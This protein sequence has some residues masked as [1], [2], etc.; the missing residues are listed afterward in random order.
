MCQT[1]GACYTWAGADEQR[2]S[3]GDLREDPRLR[4][5]SQLY[6]AKAMYSRL[7]LGR[8]RE[9][10]RERVVKEKLYGELAH[11]IALSSLTFIGPFLSTSASSFLNC[12]PDCF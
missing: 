7:V 6:V 12:I 11:E 10:K 8:E 9:R 3:W 1:L 5:R 4:G 2:D